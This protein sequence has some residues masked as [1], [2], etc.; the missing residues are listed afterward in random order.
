VL[1]RLRRALPTAPGRLDQLERLFPLGIVEESHF[2][3][4]RAGMLLF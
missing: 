4:S 2:V 3:G 1:E